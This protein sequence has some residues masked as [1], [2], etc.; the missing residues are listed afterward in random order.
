MICACWKT[1]GEDKVSCASITK[2]TDDKEVVLKLRNALEKAD[3]I[4]AH[5]G[6][7]FDIK[8][9]NA[10]LIYHNL[11]PLPQIP[12]VDTLVEIKKVAQFTSHRLDFLGKSLLGHGKLPTS[13]GLWLDALKGKK[14]AIKEM[15]EYCKVDVIRL[16]QLYNKLNP[17]FKTH[18]HV[19]VLQ[20]KEKSSCPKCGHPDTIRRGV[21]ISVSGVKSVDIQCKKCGGYHRIPDKK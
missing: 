3:V 14:S 5:N 15:T 10:R 7:K 18:P 16:E 4:V 2:P 11:L 13:D 8:K 21:R 9:L 1:L 6:K 19:G 17:Y 20:G 12:M